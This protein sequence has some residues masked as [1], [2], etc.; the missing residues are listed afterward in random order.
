MSR[1]AVIPCRPE[2]AKELLGRGLRPADA[3]EIWKIR[4]L[5][6]DKGLEEALA[7][8]LLAVTVTAD[9]KVAALCGVAE[10]SALSGAGVPWLLA[11]ADFERR[12]TAVTLLRL[13]RKFIDHWLRIFGRLENMA[14]PE[15]LVSLKYLENL[16]FTLEWGRMISGPLGHPLVPFWR[17]RTCVG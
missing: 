4:A 9:G 15:H 12:E 13:S 7:A 1:I 2:H 10:K 6:P 17:A 16:G 14:D 8:S 11:H 3:A 5:P